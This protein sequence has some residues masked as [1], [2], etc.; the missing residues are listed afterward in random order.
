MK[1]KNDAEVSLTNAEN[2]RQTANKI[3]NNEKI[4]IAVFVFVLTAVVFLLYAKVINFGY[5]ELDDY[6]SVVTCAPAYEQEYSLLK[7]FKA[8][9]MFD[10]FPSPY[11]RPVVAC[12]FIIQNKIAGTSLKLAHFSTV[13]LHVL[14]VL[15]VFFFLRRN[16][17]KTQTAFLAALLFAVCPG[18]MYGA[19]WITGIQESAGLLFFVLALAFFIE[20]L[21]SGGRQK[22][23][24][25]A[26]HIFCMLICFFTKESAV[27]YPFIFLLYYFLSK[28][29][30][31]KIQI[32]CYILWIVSIAFFFYMR[33][34]AGNIGGV[35]LLFHISAD[36]AVMMFDYYATLVFLKTPFAA[37]VTLQNYILGSIGI[38]LCFYFAFFEGKKFKFD[39]IKLF[40]FLLPVLIAAPSITA[41]DRFWFQGNRIYPMCFGFIV[42][43]FVF[44]ER[45]IESKKTKIFV[46]CLIAAFMSACFYT[47]YIRADVFKDGRSF[48]GEILKEDPKH[49]QARKFHALSHLRNGNIQYAIEEMY[50]LNKSINFSFGETNYFLAFWLLIFENYKE[51]AEVF[52]LMI[53]KEQL[54]NGQPFVGAIVSNHLLGEKEKA[55][56]YFDL[57]VKAAGVTPQ[58]AEQYLNSYFSYMLEERKKYLAVN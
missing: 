31:Q 12:A 27:S 19:V 33:R 13:F 3:F 57:F 46:F 5:T 10:K 37:K 2:N 7:A 51:A 47:S 4:K 43:F 1:K 30:Q 41:G 15:T 52:D 18:A 8:N 21:K 54:I 36:N 23:I 25:L 16:I 39:K 34:L 29:P 6:N 56:Y 40:Y 53:Q 17:F 20:Y 9:V 38:I 35:P 58:Q 48:F 26:A 42:L 11:Y 28:N 55:Q 49:V 44:F 32:H 50:A 24:F 45:F 22:Q 14:C